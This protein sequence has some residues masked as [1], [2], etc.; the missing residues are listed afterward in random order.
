MAMVVTDGLGLGLWSVLG[1]T[2]GGVN[3]GYGR[4]R[5]ATRVHTL[6]TGGISKVGLI[7]LATRIKDMYS[8]WWGLYSL[9]TVHGH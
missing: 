4:L 5:A 7:C 6:R 3:K 8:G 2:V 9:H 1:L